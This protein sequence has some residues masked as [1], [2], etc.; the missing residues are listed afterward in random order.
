VAGV[1]LGAIG[2]VREGVVVDPEVLVAQATSF[3]GQ[4]VEEER[5][6]V[7]GGEGLEPEQGGPG[8][9]RPGQREE[10]V[11]RGRPDQDEQ[12]V[13]HV[14]EQRVL[15]GP[16]EPVH[17]VEEQDGA[18]ALLAETGPSAL[19]HLA[20]VLHAGGDRRER[21]E[22][23][24]RRTGDEPGDRGLA[25]ARRSPQHHRRQPVG[26]DE[27]SQGPSR[28]EEVPLPDHLVEGAG[29]Q[30]GGQRCAS[31]E[32]LGDRSA[33]QVVGHAWIV[34]ADRPDRSSRSV[35]QIGP[36]DRSGR[37]RGPRP[38]RTVTDVPPRRVKILQRHVNLP[39]PSGVFF[40]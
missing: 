18:P 15:L 8:Q 26:L 12:A 29:A 24:A 17:L 22:R 27:H 23:L 35:G 31:L 5:T 28:A 4:R 34:R 25:R 32:A 11:L 13:F 2:E 33:E 3:V 7:V 19:G 30:S 16:A 9:E 10:R 20:D 6:Q 21:L 14:R 39:A 37:S 40:P 1:T 38:P 36:A